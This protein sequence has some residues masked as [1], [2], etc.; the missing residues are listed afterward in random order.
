MAS[1]SQILALS[2]MF[3]EDVFL[4]VMANRVDLAIITLFRFAGLSRA[5]RVNEKGS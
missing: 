2:T 4:G 5:G 1:D 3:T